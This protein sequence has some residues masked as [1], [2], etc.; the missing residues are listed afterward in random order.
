MVNSELWSTEELSENAKT[1]IFQWANSRTKVS[2]NSWDIDFILQAYL[3]SNRSLDAQTKC[4]CVLVRDKTI[5]GTGYNSFIRN[6]DDDVL[7]NLRPDKYP[8]MIHSEHN[9]ILNCA[10]NGISCNGAKAYITGPPCCSCLQYMYQAGI[11]E[12][13]FLNANKAEMTKNL[14]YDTQ[15]E[16]LSHLM[17]NVKV[18]CIEPDEETLEK[19]KKIKSC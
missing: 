1:Q 14:E 19:I 9:A 12:I 15:F 11:S 8:F 5:I 6:I 4:G 3:V 7:P 18:V 10:K 2:R 13:Y 17:K 16:I